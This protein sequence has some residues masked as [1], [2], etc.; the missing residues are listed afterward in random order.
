MCLYVTAAGGHTNR[1]GWSEVMQTVTNCAAAWCMRPQISG[2]LVPVSLDAE[3]CLAIIN[4]PALCSRQFGS[5]RNWNALRLI[6]RTKPKYP[7]LVMRT[8]CHSLTPRPLWPRKKKEGAQAEHLHFWMGESGRLP[9]SLVT[10]TVWNNGE[11][12]K[13]IW[14]RLMRICSML[15]A[16]SCQ[17]NSS[18]VCLSLSKKTRLVMQFRQTCLATDKHKQWTID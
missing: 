8:L 13:R 6:R 1:W 14:R 5:I 15:Y 11:R 18:L 3:D 7:L 12:K 4:G 17:D 2:D 16:A 10:E 9:A